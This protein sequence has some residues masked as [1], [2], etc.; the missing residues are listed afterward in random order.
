[1]GRTEKLIVLV[2]MTMNCALFSSD[3]SQTCQCGADPGERI[4]YVGP[5]A[6]VAFPDPS[7]VSIIGG[8]GRRIIRIQESEMAAGE[9][10]PFLLESSDNGSTWTAKG[11]WGWTLA[12]LSDPRF[13]YTYS[14]GC[15]LFST[16]SDGGHHW[17]MPAYTVDG[18]PKEDF[19]RK[20]TGRPSAELEVGIA[21]THPREP[22]TVYAVFW[23]TIYSSRAHAGYV[24]VE[25]SYS[26]PGMY[27]SRDAGDHW[28]LFSETVG[29]V[30]DDADARPSIGVSPSNP[31][32]MMAQSAAGVV[33]TNDGGKHWSPVGQQLE[34][35]RVPELAGR[36]ELVAQIQKKDP[37]FVP[38]KLE[39]LK[40]HVTGIVFS[41]SSSNNVFL[42][43]NKG[44]Y[45]TENAG[46]TWC[47]LPV[48][49]RRISEV[50][51]LLVDPQNPSRIFVG[52][53]QRIMVSD[54]GGCHFRPFFDSRQ[55][56]ASRSKE[57]ARRPTGA[58]R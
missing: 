45:R 24:K 57:G 22:A 11:K 7:V 9:V 39:F 37:K 44:V 13:L 5:F 53:H 50:S 58:H 27:V 20:V 28:T 30:S 38:P 46:D 47:L 51:G 17:R 16:S 41:P 52:T 29:N 12:S 32:F 33:R 34:L 4:Q 31:N 10:T 43:T 6:D 14:G 19:C 3:T 18:R 54:D 49:D 26:V 55:A 40:L 21:G 8:P 25:K 56:R 15:Q 42:V 36:A 1:M 23:A 2:L 35:N 48:G